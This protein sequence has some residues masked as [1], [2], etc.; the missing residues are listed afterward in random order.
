[1]NAIECTL[2][3]RVAWLA[4]IPTCI[5][6]TVTQLEHI[7]NTARANVVGTLHWRKNTTVDDIF[8]IRFA[9]CHHSGCVVHSSDLLKYC[10]VHRVLCGANTS[11]CN[12]NANALRRLHKLWRQSLSSA[13]AQSFESPHQC[14]SMAPVPSTLHKLARQSL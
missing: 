1:M 2:R 11:K 5:Q 8:D 4:P 3:K 9:S 6:C 10:I 12:R 13:A 7:A 14:L